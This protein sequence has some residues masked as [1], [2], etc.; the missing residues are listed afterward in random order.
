MAFKITAPQGQRS[1]GEKVDETRNYLPHAK[2]EQRFDAVLNRVG[3]DMGRESSGA[4]GGR[5]IEPP[6][7]H[8]ICRNAVLQFSNDAVSLPNQ[9]GGL[10][11]LATSAFLQAMAHSSGGMVLRAYELAGRMGNFKSRNPIM[12]AAGKSPIHSHSKSS[13][14]L[15]SLSAQ[16]ESGSAGVGA[17]GY[18][19]NGGTSYGMFQISSR[20]GTLRNFLEFL[21]KHAPKW[22]ARLR[23]SGPADTGGTDG[24]MP[25]EWN[26]IAQEDPVRF[27][28][29]QEEFIQESHYNVALNEIQEKTGVDI[30]AQSGVLQQ[31]LWS[32]AVQHGPHGAANLFSE[33]IERIQ[34]SGKEITEKQIIENVY[35][36]RASKFGLSTPSV[37]AAVRAR[38]KEEKGM[39]LAMLED[40]QAQG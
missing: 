25:R 39:A 31:V 16:F 28:K 5:G 10:A 15:G 23:E 26:R 14:D 6:L 1:S 30:S 37:R 7:G 9:S 20:Q 29:L 24:S 19:R 4:D 27:E 33:A 2:G 8:F 34:S 21:D 32:T 12:A 18:D 36:M 22:S 40:R 38:F 13:Y 11:E 35:A 17:I 3:T